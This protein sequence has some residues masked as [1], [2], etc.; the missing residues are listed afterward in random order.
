[1]TGAASTAPRQYGRPDLPHARLS[2][3][4]LQAVAGRILK[5]ELGVKADTRPT[6]GPG[7]LFS[8]DIHD[9]FDKGRYERTFP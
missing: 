1:M 8:P 3:A 2:A 6:P 9:R 5:V 7:V 4:Q